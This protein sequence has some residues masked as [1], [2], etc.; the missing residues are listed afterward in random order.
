MGSLPNEQAEDLD[1][2]L[3]ERGGRIEKKLDKIAGQMKA[4]PLPDA[5][6]SG[7]ASG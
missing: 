4:E 1:A 2:T 5:R 3:L 7:L 6:V